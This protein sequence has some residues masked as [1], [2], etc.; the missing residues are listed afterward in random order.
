M[1][2]DVEEPR[3]KAM[4][5]DPVNSAANPPALLTIPGQPLQNLQQF[6]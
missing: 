5:H 3:G 1:V 6:K 4:I 2:A